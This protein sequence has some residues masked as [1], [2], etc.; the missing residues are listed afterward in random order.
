MSDGYDW[1]KHL[2]EGE[3]VLWSGKPDDRLTLL[4]MRLDYFWW[5]FVI[6]AIPAIDLISLNAFGETG[7]TLALTALQTA[8][9][10]VLLI[11]RPWFDSLRR[12]RLRY[13][14]TD[15]RA[16]RANQGN[17][18]LLSETPLVAGLPIEEDRHETLRLLPTPLTGTAVPLDWRLHP[19][20]RPR[21][22]LT[23]GLWRAFPINGY[24]EYG[25]EFRMLADRAR[26]RAL[27]ET[28]I[29]LAP[30]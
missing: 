22:G 12:R 10:F 21:R 23:A 7:R 5:A 13:A 1:S 11:A 6:A 19:E 14:V 25:V 24:E 8:M 2:E 9:A 29:G 15:Q 30:S 17:G 28:Q 26:V 20:R 3:E 4:P 16:L 18:Q 27:I